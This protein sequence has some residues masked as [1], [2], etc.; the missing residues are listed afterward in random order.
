MLG[1]EIKERE[2]PKWM[3]IS[4]YQEGV[5]E[6]RQMHGYPPTPR[7][8]ATYDLC[9]RAFD[10][11]CLAQARSIGDQLEAIGKIPNLWFMREALLAL[12]IELR[13][14]YCP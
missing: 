10:K 14:E 3:P 9:I 2:R 12:I 8:Q 11:G 1:Q 6:Y 7:D 13:E 5:T 4:R